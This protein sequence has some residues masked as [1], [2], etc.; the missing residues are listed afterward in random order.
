MLLCLD[1][2]VLFSTCREAEDEEGRPHE[3]REL[4]LEILDAGPVEFDLGA[5]GG[6]DV[7][8]G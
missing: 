3:R 8:D 6:A 2:N 1:Q 7:G 5:G 4:V